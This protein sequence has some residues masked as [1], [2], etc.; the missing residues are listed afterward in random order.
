[1]PYSIRWGAVRT[2]LLIRIF[3]ERAVSCRSPHGLSSARQTSVF[4]VLSVAEGPRRGPRRT[5]RLTDS[6]RWSVENLCYKL[7]RTEK[8]LGVTCRPLPCFPV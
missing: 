8:H 1:M 7:T 5:P 2:I 6:C 3:L 4:S